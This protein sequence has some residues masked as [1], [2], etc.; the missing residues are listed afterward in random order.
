MSKMISIT[1]NGT[2]V[3][4]MEEA[5][6]C[7]LMVRSM[8]ENGRTEC[9]TETEGKYKLMG[10]FMRENGTWASLKE[11]EYT[12]DRMEPHI[13]GSGKITAKMVM[14]IRNGSTEINMKAI[15]LTEVRMDME[16]S[17]CLMEVSMKESSKLI[18]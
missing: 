4:K 13:Q 1:V 7:M 14:D 12:L 9:L 8:R 16:S 11:K 17:P 18:T 2:K 6:R 15:L 3:K 10:K 5:D